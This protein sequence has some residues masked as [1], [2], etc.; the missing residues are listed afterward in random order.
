[1]ISNLFIIFVRFVIEQ[2]EALEDAMLQERKVLKTNNF[3]IYSNFKYIILRINEYIHIFTKKD[4]L[5]TY[6]NFKADRMKGKD[7]SAIKFA[8]SS[9]LPITSDLGKDENIIIEILSN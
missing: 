1:M 7:T 9:N 2:N 3:I 6:S 4:I 5:Y 8:D